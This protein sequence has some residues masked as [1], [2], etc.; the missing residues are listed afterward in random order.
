M[1][2]SKHILGGI[3]GALSVSQSAGLLN[4]K[5]DAP[6]GGED[7]FGRIDAVVFEMLGEA[8]GLQFGSGLMRAGM[9]SATKGE[10]ALVV[11]CLK[12]AEPFADG[13]ARTLIAA[14]GRLDALFE[15]IGDQ[16]VAERELRVAGADHVVVRWGG[17]RRNQ[18][19]FIIPLFHLR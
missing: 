15:S 8:F 1:G 3:W 19:W 14:S 5:F 4:I 10:E 7:D 17:G 16:F 12:T 18:G 6:I 9:G 2:W 13:I 11:V